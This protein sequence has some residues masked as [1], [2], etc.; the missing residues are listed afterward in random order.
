MLL[1]VLLALGLFFLLLRLGGRGVLNE[2]LQA[3]VYIVD[4]LLAALER[5]EHAE[6]LDARHDKERLE[7]VE[8]ELTRLLFLFRRRHL[9]LLDGL[10]VLADGGEETRNARQHGGV[11]VA[12]LGQLGVELTLVGAAAAQLLAD[13]V[14]GVDEDGARLGVSLGQHDAHVAEQRLVQLVVDLLVVD[15]ASADCRRHGVL[16]VVVKV[17]LRA[18]VDEHA[19]HNAMAAGQHHVLAQAGQLADEPV[20]LGH[21]L[22]GAQLSLHL[23]VV[24]VALGCRLVVAVRYSSVTFLSQ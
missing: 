1:T 13:R 3:R 18:Q 23:G 24:R 12:A 4:H 17:G 19:A 9:L 10:H 11:L 8:L 7:H 14:D 2:A 22:S 16:L 15:E 21:E 6:A 20:L 5:V